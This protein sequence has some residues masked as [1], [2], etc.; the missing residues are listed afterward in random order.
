MQGWRRG[1]LALALAAACALALAA[2]GAPAAHASGDL[3]GVYSGKAEHDVFSFAPDAEPYVSS[4]TV[5]VND[6]RVT[7]IHVD[8]RLECPEVSILDLRLSKL[9][10]RT[11]PQ[12][13]ATDGFT[14]RRNGITVRGHIGRRKASGTIHAVKGDCESPDVAWTARRTATL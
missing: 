4:F 12:L 11:K 6:R 5:R 13:T 1:G 2:M 14:L 9:V 3:T 10:L 8:V 7:G